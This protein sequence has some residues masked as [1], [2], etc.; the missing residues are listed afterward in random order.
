[1]PRV[2]HIG[3]NFAFHGPF[4]NSILQRNLAVYVRMIKAIYRH[5]GCRF[6]YFV[7][8]DTEHLI[9]RLFAQK[10]IAINVVN[11]DA[12]ELSRYYAD[13]DVH[14]GG[15]LHSCIMA[16]GADTPCIGLAYDIKHF[17]FFDLMNMPDQCFSAT[18]FDPH[19]IINLTLKLLHAGAEE[20]DRIAA[21]RR[22]L[23]SAAQDFIDDCVKL[24][25]L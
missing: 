3:L 1:M 25:V 23:H 13:I 2:P 24:V 15:M 22:V 18:E 11:G 7:H 19:A 10:G 9:P 5:T 21:R 6:S 4:S 8:Y 17:G 12:Y 14:I 20:R 16:V